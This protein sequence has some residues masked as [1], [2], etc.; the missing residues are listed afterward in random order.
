[1]SHIENFLPV[2]SHVRWVTLNLYHTQVKIFP[3]QKACCCVF[4]SARNKKPRISSVGFNMTRLLKDWKHLE[5]LVSMRY[6]IIFKTF[7]QNE[8][9]VRRLSLMLVNNSKKWQMKTKH[10]T[11]ENNNNA[12]AKLRK[13]IQVTQSQKLQL[14]LLFI[15]NKIN[16]SPSAIH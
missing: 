16:S 15:F 11:N 6:W 3:M 1:M 2:F 4:F 8:K 5:L 9:L 13:F 10:K 14:N 7:I 12:N